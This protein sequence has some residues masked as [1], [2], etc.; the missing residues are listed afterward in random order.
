MNR[1]ITI[2]MISWFLLFFINE[3]KSSSMEP[4]TVFTLEITKP[5][6]NGQ[7]KILRLI[8]HKPVDIQ[9]SDSSFYSKVHIQPVDGSHIQ[10]GERVVSAEDIIYVKGKTK[11]SRA[12]DV[13]G[14]V[15]ILGGI[16]ALIILLPPLILA[17]VIVAIIN[18]FGGDGYVD[19]AYI[20]IPVAIILLAIPLFISR[21][22]FFRKDGYRFRIRKSIVDKA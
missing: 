20:L 8:S 3:G 7:L 16:I 11:K 2:I 17:L 14:A 15:L 22:K 13:G 5:K 21:K 4:D 6:S 19:G 10:I 9:L 12:Q 1:P 18:A